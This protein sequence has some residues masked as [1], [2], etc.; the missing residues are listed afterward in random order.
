VLLTDEMLTIIRGHHER[1]DGGGY[2]DGLSG[3][4]IHIFAAI[5]GVADSYD[6]MTSDR[7]YRAALTKEAAITELVRNKSKQFNGKVVD[8]FVKIL[9]DDK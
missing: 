3:E 9:Q 6:A 7:A 2:P 1:Y 5:V 8:I 4:N